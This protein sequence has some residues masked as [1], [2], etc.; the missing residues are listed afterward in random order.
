MKLPD[1]LAGLFRNYVFTSLDDAQALGVGLRSPPA[2]WGRGRSRSPVA[3][4]SA[5]AGFTPRPRN[6]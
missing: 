2:S 5:G 3:R 1:F 6:K 4:P